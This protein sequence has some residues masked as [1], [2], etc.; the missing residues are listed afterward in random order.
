MK[1]TCGR[2]RNMIMDVRDMATADRHLYSKKMN[3]LATRF[4][5]IVTPCARILAAMDVISAGRNAG[6][7]GG[8]GGGGGTRGSGARGGRRDPLRLTSEDTDDDYDRESETDTETDT[9]SVGM[10][11]S[12]MEYESGDDLFGE[13]HES[14]DY[15]PVSSSAAAATTAVDDAVA[16]LAMPSISSMPL[17]PPDAEPDDG[18]VGGDAA[19]DPFGGL[20]PFG[21]PPTGVPPALAEVVASGS[22]GGVSSGDVSNSSKDDGAFGVRLRRCDPWRAWR[23]GVRGG[24]EGGVCVCRCAFGA[25]DP[26]ATPLVFHPP[27]PWRQGHHVGRP[28]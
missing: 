20:P 24:G 1:L 19:D 5:V 18:A 21:A 9:E 17:P 13:S 8:G 26:P 11:F 12:D 23:C 16:P 25:I 15:P 28:R 14:G 3:E 10:A 6:G 2:V 4:L 22:E 27:I 7:A